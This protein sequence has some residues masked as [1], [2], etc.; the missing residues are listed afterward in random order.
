MASSE[1]GVSTHVL[2]SNTIVKCLE[3]CGIKDYANE[4][5]PFLIKIE[6][7]LAWNCVGRDSL[8]TADVPSGV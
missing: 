3:L 8:L 5:K 1:N 2:F 4:A 6:Y 7:C